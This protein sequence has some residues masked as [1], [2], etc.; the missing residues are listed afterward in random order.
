MKVQVSK[1]WSRLGG[2]QATL[3]R[4]W[5][6]LC[7]IHQKCEASRASRCW[8]ALRAWLQGSREAI[9]DVILDACPAASP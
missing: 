7:A 9:L 8:V 6:E 3:M 5:Q 1:P 4:M 2:V